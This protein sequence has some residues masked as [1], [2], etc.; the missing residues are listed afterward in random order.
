MTESSGAAARIGMVHYIN[1]APITETWKSRPHDRGWQL[2][3]AHPA[4]LNRMLARGEID[5][6]FVSSYEYGRRP[7]EYRLLDDLSISSSGAVG[8]V[9]LFSTVEPENLSGKSVLLSSQSKTSVCLVKIVLEK[10]FGAT[11]VY[12]DD[13]DGK[14]QD[15]PEAVL[16]IGD[17]ALRLSNGSSYRYRLDLGEVW[18]QH[19]GLP[20]VFAL[21]AVR[22]QYAREHAAQVART[23]DIL[24]R[25]RRKGCANLAAITASMQKS[26]GL[27]RDV[28]ERYFNGLQYDLDAVKFTGLQTFYTR[29]YRCGL[30]PAPVKPRFIEPDKEVEATA[31]RGK[32]SEFSSL[33]EKTL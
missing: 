26:C 3:E 12:R 4:A 23:L 25:S 10:F 5:L 27:Q 21:W 15:Q 6:G 2:V 30:I 32:H 7:D 14:A 24:N 29:L 11:P 31:L 17:D 33:F 13:A 16:A 19:T 9:F 1:M 28:L 22:T 8:S 20:F 18:M